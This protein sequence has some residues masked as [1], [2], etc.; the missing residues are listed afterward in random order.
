MSTAAK[1][2]VVVAMA[3]VTVPTARGDIA[4]ASVVNSASGGAQLELPSAT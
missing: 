1:L 4:A 3:L 2:I